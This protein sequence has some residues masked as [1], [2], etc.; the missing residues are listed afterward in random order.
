MF[1]RTENGSAVAVVALGKF[2][3]VRCGSLS[4]DPADLIRQ[5]RQMGQRDTGNLGCNCQVI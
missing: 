5:L 1:T 2:W 4:V 3:V